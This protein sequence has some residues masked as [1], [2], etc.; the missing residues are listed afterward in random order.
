MTDKLTP[1]ILQKAVDLLDSQPP[2]T[3]EYI[4][5]HGP[6]GWGLYSVATGKLVQEKQS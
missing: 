3:P 6:E 5:C 1:E 2:R 4:F